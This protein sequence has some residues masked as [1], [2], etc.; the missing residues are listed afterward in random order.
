MPCYLHFLVVVDLIED[1][2]SLQGKVLTGGW[3][4]LAPAPRTGSLTCPG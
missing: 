4:K 1:L 2:T 3:D